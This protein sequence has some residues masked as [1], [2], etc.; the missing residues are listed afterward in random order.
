MSK[1]LLIRTTKGWSSFFTKVTPSDNQIPFSPPLSLLYIASTLEKEGHTVKLIDVIFEKYP[2]EKIRRMLSS[3]DVVIFNIIPGNQKESASLAQFIHDNQPD[4]PII[5][6]GLYCTTYPKGAL[7]DVPAANICIEGEGEHIINPIIKIIENG[8]SLSNIPGIFYRKKSLIKPGAKK[9]D[10]KNL[11]S[12]PFP[13]RHLVKNYD[14]GMVNGIHLCKPQSTSILASRGCPYNCYFCSNKLRNGEYRQR[15][16]E[17]VLKE[18][19]EIQKDYNSVMIEDDNFLADSRWAGKVL[20]GLIK[21][22]SDLELFIAGARVDSANKELYHKMA[23]A[24]VKFISFGIESGNQDVLNFYNKNITLPK[25]RKAVTLAQEMNIITS[26]CFIFGAPIETK[27][28]LKNT[29]NFSLSLPLDLALFR[30]LTYQRGSK[31]WEEAVAKGLIDKDNYYCFVGSGKTAINFT[32]KELSDYCS[33]AF[34]RFYF[35]PT[36]LLRELMRSIKRKDF[37]MLKLMYSAK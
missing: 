33:Y 6:H 14:Y 34:K 27:E 32:D 7:H 20:D 2:I 18:F 16:P 12:L 4:I 1:L 28:H 23:K 37:T 3:I 17:N 10:I 11:D 5:I 8:K 9:S 15:S 26:G 36:Y 13:S 22:H 31:M 25:I 29:L 35:R 21:N 19:H 24:G 30:Q